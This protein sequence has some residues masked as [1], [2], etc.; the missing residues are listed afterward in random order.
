MSHNYDRKHVNCGGPD[1]TDP[2]YPYPPCQLDNAGPDAHYGFQTTN[3]TVIAPTAAIDFMAYGTNR[4][5]SDYNWKSLFGKINALAADQPAARSSDQPNL[6]EASNVV[7]L[8]GAITPTTNQGALNYAWTVPTGALSAHVLGKWQTF[9]SPAMNVSIEPNTPLTVTYHLRLFDNNNTLLDDRTVTLQDSHLHPDSIAG[10]NADDSPIKNFA[11]TFP[12]PAGTVARLDLLADETLLARLQPGLS[13]PTLSIVK[14]AGGETFSNQMTIIWNGADADTNDR[15]LFNVQ[16]SP[17]N[18]TTWL[19]VANDV[20]G[21]LDTHLVTLTLNSLAGLPGSAPGQG[22]I[23]VMASDGYHTALATSAGFT[24]VNHPP[25]PFITT[26]SEN[27][28]VQPGGS[29][30][31]HGGATDAEDGGLNDAAL[32]WKI[33]STSVGTGTEQLVAGLAPGLYNVTVDG[34]RLDRAEADRR[35]HDE[36]RHLDHPGRQWANPGWLLRRRGVCE[37][38]AA[39]TQPLRR[40]W[41]VHCLPSAHGYRSVGLL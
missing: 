8:T 30:T 9:A 25:D 40:W 20:P 26:P 16:Y 12:A 21:T 28:I 1:D 27:E 17:D 15:L 23:R 39:A 6:A 37:C 14:P 7:M 18:G 24:V 5:A 13:M 11:A 38:P 35:P 10:V 19:P 29:I 31:L 3:Q 22:H 33:N 32:E 41:S 36:H 2:G 4:W 34:S